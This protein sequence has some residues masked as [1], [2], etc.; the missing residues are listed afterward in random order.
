MI[1]PKKRGRLRGD[2][3]IPMLHCGFARVAGLRQI[4]AHLVPTQPLR[5]AS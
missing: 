3:E 4:S 2:L 5:G 1:P